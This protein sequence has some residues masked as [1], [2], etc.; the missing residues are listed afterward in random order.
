MRAVAHGIP[1][2]LPVV[3]AGTEVKTMV[4]LSGDQFAS[5]GN[6]STWAGRSWHLARRDVQERQH[7]RRGGASP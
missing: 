2:L 3:E 7:A 5:P 1:L 4:V 6:W